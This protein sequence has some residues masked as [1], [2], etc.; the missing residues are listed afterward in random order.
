[1]ETINPI[2][3]VLFAGFSLAIIFP[4]AAYLATS[5]NISNRIKS[6]IV[7]IASRIFL[8]TIAF[9]IM[10]KSSNQGNYHTLI[11]GFAIGVLT[12]TLISHF[13]QQKNKK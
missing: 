1:M 5:I 11:I 7:G 10:V 8:G 9:S 13:M 2:I 12:F 4:I 3:T 6:N